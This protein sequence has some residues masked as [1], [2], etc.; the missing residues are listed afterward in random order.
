VSNESNAFWTV[1]SY[2][3]GDI[4]AD[5]FELQRAAVPEPGDGEVLVKTTHLVVSPPLRMAL[6]TGGI[7][8]KPLPIGSL[9]RGSGQGR[10]VQSKHPDFAEGDLVAG[11]FGWQEYAVSNGADQIPLTRVQTYGDLPV[12]TSLHVMGSGGAT[13]FIG[14]YEYGHPQIGDVVVVSAAA[15]NVGSIVCQLAKLAGCRV[16]GIAGS[17]EKCN[18][19]TNTL[20]VDAAINYKSED[21]STSLA[22]HCPRGVD[23]YFDNVGGATLDA[24]LEHIN[25]GARVVLCGATSQY[26]GDATWYGPTKYFNLVYKQASMHGFYI[27]NFQSRFP[28]ILAR[29]QALIEDGRLIYAEDQMTGVESLPNALIN[30]LSGRNFG[31]QLVN[32]D[33]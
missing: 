22:Q 23:I 9:M 16:V 2:P 28:D 7:A 5:N 26:E 29:L 15:G 11:P 1:K 6:G 14:L 17:D 31:P 27:F 20:G 25:F 30:V 13:A 8:G 33:A 24:V 21:L 18:W 12:T 3:R 4:S 32:L 10:V 19:L